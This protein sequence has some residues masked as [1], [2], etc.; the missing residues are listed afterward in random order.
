MLGWGG[1]C[2]CCSADY[3]VNDPSCCRRGTRQLLYM[4]SG[5]SIQKTETL[6]LKVKVVGETFATLTSDE[7]LFDHSMRCTYLQSSRNVPDRQSCVGCVVDVDF[8]WFAGVAMGSG[9]CQSYHIKFSC[10]VPLLER[11]LV[12]NSE[13]SGDSIQL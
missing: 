12:G 9:D 8:L 4:D 13:V 11:I 6:S 1:T 10:G 7:T 2:A 5:V 3:R